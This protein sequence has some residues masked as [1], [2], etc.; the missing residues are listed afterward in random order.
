M[1]LLQQPKKTVTILI[2][3]DNRSASQIISRMV[4]MEFPEAVV[5][6]ADNGQIGVNLFKKYTPDIVITD[7]QMPDMDGIEMA[8]EIK[9]IKPDLKF[10]VFTAYSDGEFVEQF[11][12]IGVHAYLLKPLDLNELMAVVGKCI[13]EMGDIGGRSDNGSSY[14]SQ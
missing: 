5:Y 3:E 10:I 2:A 7:I 4:A 1:H 14:A 13:E 11:N 12:D 6:S 8:I 9:S